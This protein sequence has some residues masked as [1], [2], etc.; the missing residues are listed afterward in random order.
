VNYS[1]TAGI[2]GSF[3]TMLL[4]FNLGFGIYSFALGQTLSILV[5]VSW[6]T[7][8][9]WR[10]RL[11]PSHWDPMTRSAWR[12]LFGFGSEVFLITLG[13]QLINGSQTFLLTRL[14]GLE[15][16]AI[17]SIMTKVFT[18]LTQLVTRL[19]SVAIPAFSEMFVR[20]E[21]ERLCRRYR[22]V[23]E[24]SVLASCYFGLF[25]VFGNSA[26]VNIWTKGRIYWHPI[27]DCLLALWFILSIQSASHNGLI[28]STKKVQAAKFFYLLE[29]VAFILGAAVFLPRAGIPGMLACSIVCTTLLTLAYG[30][31]RVARLFHVGV[32]NVALKWSA[33]AVRL[34]ITMLPIGIPLALITRE[35][36]ALRLIG[37]VI[38]VG[39]IA[40][41]A[42]VRFCIS[43]DLVV[44][45]I[46]HLPATS[47][48]LAN[49][50]MGQRSSVPASKTS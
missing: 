25:I 23:F 40:T 45:I 20:G 19:S 47:R 1:L 36:V 49:I 41:A 5:V 44:E 34:L 2:M 27:N 32:W 30:T 6:T 16:A 12:D 3:A 37:C 22:A 48:R 24:L 14:L 10:L 26:F 33:S 39:I 13:A 42:A 29:G 31:R 4:L 17:W 11:F 46:S 18:L 28:I 43:R 50:I 15:A 38:P 21:H 8:A 35:S 9:A 7:I